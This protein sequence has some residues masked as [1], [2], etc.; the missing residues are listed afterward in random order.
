[1]NESASPLIWLSFDLFYIF[2]YFFSSRIFELKDL[3]KDAMMTSFISAS[4]FL[5]ADELVAANI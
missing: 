1:M 4:G 3:A 5:Y 2:F